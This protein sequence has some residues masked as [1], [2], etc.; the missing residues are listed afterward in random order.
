MD[1]NLL[2]LD[3]SQQSRLGDFY[4]KIGNYDSKTNEVIPAI[5]TYQRRCLYQGLLLH[6]ILMAHQTDD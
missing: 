3:L 4:Q 2:P 5:L 1:T 6:L